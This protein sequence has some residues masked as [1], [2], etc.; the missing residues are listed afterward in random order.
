MGLFDFLAA[1]AYAA[2]VERI[3]AA[4]LGILP[5]NISRRQKGIIIDAAQ[6]GRAMGLSAEKTAEMC[7]ESVRAMG[8]LDNLR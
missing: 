1:S 3:V 7:F 2:K 4:R 6:S 5:I 8:R